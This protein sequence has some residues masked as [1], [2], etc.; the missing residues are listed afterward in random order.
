[1]LQPDFLRWRIR[2]G[3]DSPMVVPINGDGG[4]DFRAVFSRQIV[5]ARQPPGS[6]QLFAF[7][8]SRGGISQG[9]INFP[10]GKSNH[11]ACADRDS[12]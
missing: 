12:P 2:Q 4:R 3:G 11:F 9:N 8:R 6:S 7:W 1:M 10:E 5:L